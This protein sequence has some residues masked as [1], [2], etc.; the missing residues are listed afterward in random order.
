M[1][2]NLVKTVRETIVFLG[3]GRIT[4]AIIE[5]LK[6]AESQHR[7]VVHDRHAN[8]LVTLRRRFHVRVETDLHRAIAD[9]TMLIVAVRPDSLLAVLHRVGRIEWPVAAISFAPGVPLAQLRWQ[10]GPHAQWLR[11]MPS[12]ACSGRRGLTALAFDGGVSAAVK[13]RVRRLFASMG[14]VLEIAERKF[15]AF[16]ATY[17]VS[18]GYHALFVL[19]SAAMKLGLDQKTAEIAAAHALADGILCWRDGRG[20]LE[21]LLR[22]AATPGG[23]AATVISIEESGGYSRLIERALRAG[24]ARA[25]AQHLF[26]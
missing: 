22:E 18:H 10:L 2:R 19:L 8:K 16:T 1:R 9:A 26:F 4:S 6:R 20:S 21:E 11:A 17:S 24:L 13:K 23:I 3:G 15:D 12:P 25:R 14:S 7:I 5:G